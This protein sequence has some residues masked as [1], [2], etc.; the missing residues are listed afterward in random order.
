MHV[1]ARRLPVQLLLQHV[2]TEYFHTAEGAQ[3]KRD[4]PNG[5]AQAAGN[6]KLLASA[7]YFKE[8]VDAGLV[9]ADDLTAAAQPKEAFLNGESVFFLCMRLSDYEVTTEEGETYEFAM[10]PWLSDDGASNTLTVMVSRYFGLSKE[11][12]EPGNEQKL[13]DALKL[14]EYVSTPEGQQALLAGT[15]SSSHYVSSLSGADIPEDSPFYEL[16]DLLDGGHT[17]DLV[18]TG[19][20]DLIV[21][22]AQDIGQLIV[23]AVSPEQMLADFDETYE[24]VQRNSNI[25]AHAEEDLSWDETLRLVGIATGRAVGADAALVS[26]GGYNEDHKINDSGV[27][28]YLYSGDITVETVNVFRTKCFSFSVLEMTGAQIKALADEGFDRYGDG[29]MFPY[30]L[31]T[32][33]DVALEDDKVYRLAVGTEDLAKDLREQAVEVADINSRDAVVDYLSEL[34]T[35]SADDIRWE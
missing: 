24:A 29:S 15:T 12:L 27:N 28:W 4:F 21:P 11:L 34:G 32:K 23:G 3:W 16:K 14:I 2:N 1:H 5:E 31:V 18:Y 25:L 30:T 8:W 26:R 20:E 7:E 22:L 35:F 10:M 33:G 9:N 19:W 6:E 13:E 17:V